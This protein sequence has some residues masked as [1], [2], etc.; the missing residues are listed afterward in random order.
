MQ[1]KK[2]N[3][4]EI[5]N[6][7]SE[8]AHWLH[9]HLIAGTQ[10]HSSCFSVCEQYILITQWDAVHVLSHYIMSNLMCGHL[11]MSQTVI[12]VAY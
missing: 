1:F 4:V 7:L 2:S 9:S 6:R 8:A 11:I 3:G 10:A 5:S 12:T